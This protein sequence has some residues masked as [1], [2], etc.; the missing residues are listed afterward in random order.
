MKTRNFELKTPD[1]RCDCFEARPAGEGPHQPVLFFMDAYGP[2]AQLHAMAERLAEQGCHVLLPNL[3]YRVRRAPVVDG[4]FPISQERAQEM[5]AQVL[6]LVRGYDI[7]AGLRDAGMFLEHLSAEA[8]GKVLITGYCMGGRMA[9]LTAARCP[10]RVAV[11]ASFHGGGLATDAP[12][13]PH[14]RVK[15]IQARIY[16]GHAD[17]DPSMPQEQIARLEEALKGAR[18]DYRT[19]LYAGALHGF[20]MADLPAFD[21]EASRRHWERLTELIRVAKR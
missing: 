5:R 13:S 4:R 19:E 11:T 20:T 12:D 16:V 18:A 14:L 8:P 2:R 1:G 9:L 10:E 21:A 15:Q 17:Q 3:F 7:E 6:Q